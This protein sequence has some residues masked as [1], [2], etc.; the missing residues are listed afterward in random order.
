MLGDLQA[1]LGG[2]L[3]GLEVVKV[4]CGRSLSDLDLTVE[5]D[6]HAKTQLALE[7]ARSEKD[8][9]DQ[10]VKELNDE[11]EA[12]LGALQAGN[13]GNVQQ[14]QEE[15]DAMMERLKEKQ[16]HAEEKAK[17]QAGMKQLKLTMGR[18]IKGHEYAMVQVWREKVASAKREE[19]RRARL[20]GAFTFFDLDGNGSLDQDEFFLIGQALNPAGW[21]TA[22]SKAAFE[23]IDDDKSGELEFDRGTR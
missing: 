13:S 15:H 1:M 22:R 19:M 16:K 2:T 4:E 6:A 3:G 18:F 8:L 23:K 14:M 17:K 10:K 11:H 7:Q 9:L 12:T 5:K 21:T 20:D